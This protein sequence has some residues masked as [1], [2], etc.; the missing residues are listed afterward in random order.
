MM[1]RKHHEIPLIQRQINGHL[2][3][4]SR[5]VSKF[6][7]LDDKAETYMRVAIWTYLIKYPIWAGSRRQVAHHEAGHFAAYEVFGRGAYSASIHGSPGGHNG[8]GGSVIPNEELLENFHEPT[9]NN[10][11]NEAK[12]TLAGPWVEELLAN[13]NAASSPSETLEFNLLVAKA[14]QLAGTEFVPLL[15]QTISETTDFIEFYNE[16]IWEIADCLERRKKIRRDSRGIK[17]AMNAIIRKRKMQPPCA[18]LYQDQ[19]PRVAIANTPPVE[20]LIRKLM[21]PGYGR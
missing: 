18:R 11:I 9:F 20:Y 12:I 19:A 7:T 14:A 1:S 15:H 3:P 10:Y 6:L 17:D 16:E 21:E 8:W 5:N 13:G 2:G 4:L